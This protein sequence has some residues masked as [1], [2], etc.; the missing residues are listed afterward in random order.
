MNILVY[1]DEWA[2]SVVNLFVENSVYFLRKKGHNVTI[3]DANNSDAIN[4][5]LNI[6]NI[7]FIATSPAPLIAPIPNIT[8]SLLS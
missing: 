6:F 8:T 3:I 1:K 5:L 2:Y 7:E 4:I